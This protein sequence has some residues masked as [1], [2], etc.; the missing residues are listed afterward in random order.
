MPRIRSLSLL[1]FFFFFFLI[2]LYSQSNHLLL[3]P[4]PPLGTGALALTD[5]RGRCC[6]SVLSLLFFVVFPSGTLENGKKFDSS[7][8]RG[9]PFK[10]CMGKH[11]VIRGWEEGVAQMSLGERSMLTISADFAYGSQGHPGIIPPNSTLLFDVELMKM[12]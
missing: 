12:D 4:P 11:E 7:R 8:D 9:R 2:F 5:K 1:F 6:N 10:F 3:L